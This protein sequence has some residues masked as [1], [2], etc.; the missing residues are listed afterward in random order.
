M[1]LF[2]ESGDFLRAWGLSV[3]LYCIIY[4]VCHFGVSGVLTKFAKIVTH[5]LE[6]NDDATVKSGV[7]KYTRN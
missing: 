1:T 4:T 5:Q 2:D 7:W 3:P 6:E